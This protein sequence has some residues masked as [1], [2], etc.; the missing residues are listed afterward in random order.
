MH[1]VRQ[2]VK[3]LE[4]ALAAQHKALKPLTAALAALKPCLD[5]YWKYDHYYTYTHTSL[6]AAPH[7]SVCYVLW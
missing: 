2:Q 4:A 1:L 6:A 5:N 3:D 7:P